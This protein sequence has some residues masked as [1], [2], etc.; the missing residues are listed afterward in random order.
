MT[1]P[2]YRALRLVLPE[3]EEGPDGSTGTA[4]PGL[5]HGPRGGLQTVSGRDSVRQALLLLFSTR[6]GERVNRPEYGCSLHRVLF[7]PADDT[8]AGLA[9]HYVRQAVARWEA[10]VDVLDVDAFPAPEEPER[11]EVRLTYR[12]RATGDVDE[13]AV[14]VPLA[15]GGGR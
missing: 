3:V 14:D 8:T 2:R 4:G 1:G 15:G 5:Q 13:L 7:S 9:I 12:I 10:R 11:L 6:P